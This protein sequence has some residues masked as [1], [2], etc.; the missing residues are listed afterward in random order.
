[1][2]TT[3]FQHMAERRL[4]EVGNGGAAVEILGGLA[5]VILSI[6]GLTGLASSSLTAIAGIV[7]GVAVLAQG[8][9][10]AAEYSALYARATETASGSVELRGGMSVE[11]MTGGAVIVLGILSV[12]GDAAP[13]LL[14]VL[15]IVGGTSLLATAGAVQRLS[16]LKM[17]VAEISDP[18]QQVINAATAGASSSQMLAGVA[19]IVLGIV[20]LASTPAGGAAVTATTMP[21]MWELLTLVGLLVIGASIMMSGGSLM[22]RLVQLFGPEK[23]QQ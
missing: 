12:L 4:I 21:A 7:F 9:A 2:S 16:S 1:M 15:V 23:P 19:A 5:V 22:E 6:L 11:L 18:A 14:P 3:T 17:E 10:I 13:I 20:A 8:A